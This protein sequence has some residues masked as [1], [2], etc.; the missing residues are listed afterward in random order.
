MAYERSVRILHFGI[1]IS[2]LFQ[3]ATDQIIGLPEP[4]HFHRRYDALLVGV[5][6]FVGVIALIFVGVYLVV[7]LD[8]RDSR[9][10]LFPWMFPDSRQQLWRE[11]RD[12]LPAWLRGSQSL[13]ESGGLLAGAVHGAGIMLALALGLSGA[14]LFIGMGP[15]GVMPPDIKVVREAHGLMADVMW[16]FVFG[17]AGMA[18]LHEIKGHRL[19]QAMFHLGRTS[20][21]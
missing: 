1:V 3:L 12:D 21:E 20:G 8:D 6:E 10:R 18:L 4:G 14:L 15:G 13:P 7:R 19:M 5:H 2:I 17:H 16:L 11:L 9:Q